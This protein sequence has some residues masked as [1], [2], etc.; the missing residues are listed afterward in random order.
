MD[1]VVVYETMWGNARLVAK[2]IAEGLETGHVIP[3]HEAT[4]GVGR[5]DLLVVGGPT[6]AR[7]ISSALTRRMA[8]Q[9]ASESTHPLDAEAA[10]APGLRGWLRE[11]PEVQGAHAL[12]FDTRRDRPPLIAGSASRAIARR[13]RERGYVVPATASFVV[14]RGDGPLKRG[15]LERATEWAATFRSRIAEVLAGS[16]CR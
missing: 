12:A 4:G 2:A 6:H 3:V 13:L 7:G 16:A 11:I 5:A 15:E 9:A 8:V 14:E 10:R 1:C